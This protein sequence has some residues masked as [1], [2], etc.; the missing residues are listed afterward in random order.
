MKIRFALD[1]RKAGQQKCSQKKK[2]SAR[3]AWLSGAGRE[4]TKAKSLALTVGEF[5]QQSR[6]PKI[7]EFAKP[8]MELVGSK[9]TKNVQ[10]VEK[11]AMSRVLRQAKQKT[12]CAFGARPVKKSTS[13]SSTCGRKKKT[14]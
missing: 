14:A 2:R 5:Y 3:P 1:A 4:K 9:W 12:A 7:A 13:E 11:I 6:S 10:D 8:A